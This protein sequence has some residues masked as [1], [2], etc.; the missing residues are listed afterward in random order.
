MQMAAKV[1]LLDRVLKLYGPEAMEARRALRDTIADAVRQTWPAERTGPARLNP[2][3][4]MGGALYVEVQRLSPQ[5][6]MHRGLK[7]QVYGSYGPTRGASVPAASAGDFVLVDA[8]ADCA[9]V[10]AGGYLFWL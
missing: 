1:A 7:T 2:N 9:D 5:D 4:Q 6:D 8:A 10:V 3:Q